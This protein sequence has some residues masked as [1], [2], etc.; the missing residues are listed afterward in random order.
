M[1]PSPKL[2]T[3][4]VDDSPQARRLLKMMLIEE[5]LPVEIVAEAGN[6]IEAFD[7]I[8]E[9]KPEL[10]LLDIE[11]PEKSGLELAEQLLENEINCEIVFTTAYSEYA[12]QAFRLSAIDYLLKPVQ[13]SDLK[14][15]IEKVNHKKKLTFDQTRLK[16]LTQ[17]LKETKPQNLCLPVSNGYEYINLQDIEYLAAEGAYV[18]IVLTNAR[19]IMVSKNLKHFETLLEG[20]EQFIRVHR[21]FIINKNHVKSVG[22]GEKTM[23][24]MQSNQAIDLA[25]DRKQDFWKAMEM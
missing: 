22:K 17:N 21:S 9:L 23:I 15:A 20:F 4:I 10:L 1:K 25:R 12:I 19:E 5:A 3:M 6:A 13:E 2:K 11:M 24:I 8:Q 14:E 7:L 18:N 16:T